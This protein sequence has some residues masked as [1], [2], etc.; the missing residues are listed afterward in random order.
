MVEEEL[1]TEVGE[2][3]FRDSEQERKAQRSRESMA[4]SYR[5][6]REVQKEDQEVSTGFDNWEVF[7]DLCQWCLRSQRRMWGQKCYSC[8]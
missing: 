7:G 5:C 1:L 8:R 2:E 4:S 6:S 3:T